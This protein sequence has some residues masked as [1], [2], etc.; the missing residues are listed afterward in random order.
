MLRAGALFASPDIHQ[1]KNG[2]Q[3]DAWFRELI[4]DG[5]GRTTDRVS[6]NDAIPFQGAKLLDEHLVSNAW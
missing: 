4:K 6:C 3:P 1:V 2:E 5:T